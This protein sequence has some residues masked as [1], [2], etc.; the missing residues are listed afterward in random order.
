MLFKDRTDAGKQ[1][2]KKLSKFK[3]I[4]D[5]LILA[6]PRGGVI[7]GFEVSKKLKLPLDLVVPRKISAPFNNEYAIGA[8]T[9]SGEGIFN[10][11]ALK[12]LQITDS[13]LRK[14]VAQEQKEAQRRIKLYRGNIEPLMLKNKI[15]ILIDDGIATGLTMLAAIKSIVTQKPLKIIVAIPVIAK[16]TIKAIEKEVTGLIY[17]QAPNNFNAVGEFYQQFNQTTDQ[18]VIDCMQN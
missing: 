7:V 15:I 12:Y 1:L 11:Q 13:Y 8:I 3:N 14:K 2:A 10:Q 5:A 16:D 17:I 4:K 18:E 9:E 6:L